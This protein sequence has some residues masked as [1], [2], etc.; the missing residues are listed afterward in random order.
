MSRRLAALL[1][2]IGGVCAV[3][4]VAWV[5]LHGDGD[6]ANTPEGTLTA[7]A[8]AWS[9]GDDAGAAQLTD[10]PAAAR[11]ALVASRQGLDGATVQVRPGTATAGGE[12]ARGPV[13]LR[14]TVPG[15]GPWTYRTRVALRRVDDDWRVVWRPTVVHPALNAHTRLGTRLYAEARGSI[16]DRDGRALVKA[17]P[18]M[19]VSVHVT[20]RG[21][22]PDATAAALADV[23]DIDQGPLARTLRDARPGR[24]IPVITLRLADYEDVADRLA[25]IDGVSLARDDAQL[26]PR[27]GFG[28]A[29]LG[30]VGPATAEQIKRSDGRLHEGDEVGQSGLEATY[31]KQLAARPVT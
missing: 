8:R 15:F 12:R 1:A 14:W 9:R 2:L 6:D 28:A 26:A 31:D 4:V 24:Y 16:L 30:A 20:R 10:A 3:A 18:V 29:L 23:L 19:H 5:L 13:V 11:R 17:R 27:R 7:F 25:D 21:P 22:D